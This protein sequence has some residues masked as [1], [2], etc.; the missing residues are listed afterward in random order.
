MIYPMRFVLPHVRGIRPWWVVRLGLLLYDRIGGKSR[1]PGSRGLRPWDRRFQA[2]LKRTRAGFVSSDCV[3]ADSRLKLLNAMDAAQRGADI[4][5]RTALISARRAGN[6]WHAEL[7]H[8]VKAKNR[9]LAKAAGPWVT[10]TRARTG[11]GS[12]AREGRD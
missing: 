12:K 11:G 3:V 1:L 6:S 5:A 10:K 9:V 8:G 2:P 7:S 4:R